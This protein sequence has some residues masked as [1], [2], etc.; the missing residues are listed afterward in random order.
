MSSDTFVIV[1]VQASPPNFSSSL[2]LV[3]LDYTGGGSHDGFNLS[4]NLES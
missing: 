1:S 3:F 2:S 4:S